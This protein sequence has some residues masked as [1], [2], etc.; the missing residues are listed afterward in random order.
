[1]R[2]RPSRRLIGAT[3][4]IVTLAVVAILVLPEIVRRAA[5]DRLGKMI[6]APVSIGDVDLN[7]FTGRAHV[8][9]FVIGDPENPI[10]YFP[11][12]S[13]AFSRTALLTGRIDLAE[14][15]MQKPAVTIE[16]I[17]ADRYNIDILRGNTDEAGGTRPAI[18][19]D[20]IE[21]HDG[22]I[23]LVDRTRDPDYKLNLVSLNVAAGPIS[24]LPQDDGPVTGF[25]AAFKIGEGSVS[26]SGEGRASQ[27]PIAA[28]L[29]ANID[30]VG[31][32]A[33]RAYLPHDATLKIEDS[34]VSGHARY[35]VR[36]REG[37]TTEHSLTADLS[38]GG[39][40]V[41]SDSAAHPLVAVSGLKAQNIRMDF[42]QNTAA[43]ERLIL[44]NP[45]LRLERDATGWNVA[46]LFAASETS[47]AANAEDRS[48]AGARM[49]LSLEHVEG[50]NA[51][52]EFIDRTV[53]PVVSSS[54]HH[55]DLLA[56]N[57]SVLPIF[58]LPDIAVNAS[59][60]QGSL[61]V[62]GSFA[63]RP[64]AGQLTIT[65]SRLPFSSFRGYLHQLLRGAEWSGD[66]LNGELKLAFVAGS[67]HRV[68]AR[69]SGNLS[70]ERVRLRFPD[71]ENAFLSSRHVRVDIRSLR[72]G[73]DRGIDI[74]RLQMFGANLTLV[75]QRGGTLNISR[76]WS[77]R[78]E[79]RREENTASENRRD[80][81][82]MIRRITMDESVVV[83]RDVTVSPAYNTRLSRLTG[84]IDNLSR[85]S[86]TGD[87]KV[88][89]CPR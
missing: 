19:V 44:E 71:E 70:G 41:L 25:N 14:L 15:I 37:T 73:K 7:L 2:Y 53:E 88:G 78:E 86:R 74:E 62:T 49:A 26:L 39:I 31:L 82:V 16:R 38:I 18:S 12:I 9:D 48:G 63:A 56:R 76:L 67:D 57:V 66:T 45:H 10:L 43:V 89:W 28:E 68:G 69:I 83:V 35:L 75:R 81:P 87:G 36:S 84:Q 64:L 4:I 42:L 65:G 51:M 61:A 58:E 55:A 50:N 27:R 47:E 30:G 52:I 22:R 24:T 21:V 23:V 72:T 46:E 11:E 34:L 40:G 77:A 85:Q 60:E 6:A 79:P 8:D 17:A 80:A 33:F 13:M 54:F 3:F 20:R 1:M 29:N 32:E 5:S 59:T